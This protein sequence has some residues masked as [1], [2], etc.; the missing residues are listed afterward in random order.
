MS[1]YLNDFSIHFVQEMLCLQFNLVKRCSEQPKVNSQQA[2][3]C[4]DPIKKNHYFLWNNSP[5]QLRK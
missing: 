5:V 3:L 4:I 1:K 2:M